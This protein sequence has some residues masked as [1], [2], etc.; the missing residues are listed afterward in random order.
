MFFLYFYLNSVSFDNP[1]S[2][3]RRLLA[4]QFLIFGVVNMAYSALAFLIVIVAALMS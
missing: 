2:E 3:K 4:L 1:M